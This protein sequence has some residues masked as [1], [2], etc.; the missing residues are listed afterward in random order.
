MLTIGSG[1]VCTTGNRTLGGELLLARAKDWNFPAAFSLRSRTKG[2]NVCLCPYRS[3]RRIVNSF[4]TVWKS[5]PLLSRRKFL[6]CMD[7]PITPGSGKNRDI[8]KVELPPNNHGWVRMAANEANANKT[9]KFFILLKG[10]HYGP[11]RARFD[12]KMH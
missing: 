5:S 8:P 4:F 2:W 6:S 9:T 1:R 7:R 12:W 11:V 3:E 10:Q